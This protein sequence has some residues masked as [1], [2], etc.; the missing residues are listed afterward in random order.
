MKLSPDWKKIR[1][2][3]LYVA[4]PLYANS[5][6]VGYHNSIMALMNLCMSNGIRMATKCVGCDSLVPRARNRLVAHYLEYSATDFLFIDADITFVAE[7]AL[8][9][10]ALDAPI[11]CGIYPRKQIDWNRIALAARSGVPPDRLARYGYIPVVNFEGGEYRLDELMPVRRMGTGFLR[12]RR[13]VFEKMIVHFGDKIAFDYH[14]DE[15]H[16]KGPGYD[17]FPTGPDVRYPLGTGGRQYLSE[18]YGFSELAK[19]CGFPLYAAP[20]VRLIHSG[21]FDFEGDMSVLDET[22]METDAKSAIPVKGADADG[23][24]PEAASMSLATVP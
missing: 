13:E 3:S 11:I 10:L 21:H 8:S 14:S 1:T 7:D 18:D 22:A 19:E 6:L 24:I 5:M 15:P 2:R 12:I 16:F 23:A 20:W 17:L 4:S 9:L